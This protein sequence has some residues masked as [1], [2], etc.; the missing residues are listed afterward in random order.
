MGDIAVE[1]TLLSALQCCTSDALRDHVRIHLVV[2]CKV[3]RHLTA[4][5]SVEIEARRLD[6][7]KLAALIPRERDQFNC[8]RHSTSQTRCRVRQ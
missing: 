4:S 8:L 5:S 1:P 7:V 3:L 2:G 6:V